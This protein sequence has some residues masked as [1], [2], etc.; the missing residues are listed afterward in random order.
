M[1]FERNSD[2]SL[3]CI[4]QRAVHIPLGFGL[5]NNTP[6]LFFSK[7]L[8]KLLYIDLSCKKS[9]F[10]GKFEPNCCLFKLFVRDKS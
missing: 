5:K 2:S 7:S 1:S 10:L 8:L 9:V 3:R 4:P 6:L